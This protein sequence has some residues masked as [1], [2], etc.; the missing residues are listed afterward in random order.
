MSFGSELL[1]RQLQGVVY[2]S[3]Y[4]AVNNDCKEANYIFLKICH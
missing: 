3:I 2:S 1:R 4:V